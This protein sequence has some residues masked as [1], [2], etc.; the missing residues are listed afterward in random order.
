MAVDKTTLDLYSD[1]LISSLGG[2]TTATELSALTNNVL[3]NDKVSRFLGG[4]YQEK[5]E[6]RHT[7]YTSQDLWKLVKPIVR[8][9]E[10]PSSYLVIDDTIQEKQYSG[11]ND[12]ICWHFDH[13]FN[14]HVKG[15]NILNFI[16]V[17]PELTIPLALEVIKKTEKYTTITEG[18]V[19]EKRKSTQTKNELLR[20]TLTQITKNEV[21]FEWVLID[22]W[23][24]ANETLEQIHTAKKKYIV[25]LKSN[26]K[27]TLSSR[28]K[29]KG[30]WLKLD[31]LDDSTMLSIENNPQEVWLEGL[32]HSVHLVKQIF[33]NE[34]GSTGIQFLITNGYTSSRDDILQ[35]YKKRWKVEEYHKTLK[36]HLG[37]AKSP[38]KTA[39]TQINH[40]FCSVYAY[41]QLEF[42]TKS[43]K[44]TNHFQL[45]A[46]LYLEA[47]KKSFEELGKL[48]QEVRVGVGVGCER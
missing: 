1:Y 40:F 31:T 34:D 14:R 21:A 46:K 24:G 26:R 29:L 37:L 11:E 32:D 45:K 9:H 12:I 3:S 10:T 41:L 48:R 35:H 33:T 47:L 30:A 39:I 7:E 16:L 28:D 19:V 15:I 38:T 13:C 42:L 23:F 8:N 2:L 18:K 36:S 22:S 4:A 17:T 5:G 43:T 20:D 6:L 25:P 44:I 27:L